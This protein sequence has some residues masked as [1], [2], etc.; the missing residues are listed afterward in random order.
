MNLTARLPLAVAVAC[1]GALAPCRAQLNPDRLY[2]GVDRAIPMTLRAPADAKGE[3]EIALFEPLVD[4]PVATAAAA[5]GRVDL[6]GLFPS[7]WTTREPKVRYA[8]AIVGGVRI[9]APVVLQPMLEPAYAMLDRANRPAFKRLTENKLVYS[10]LRA[11]GD[12]LVVLDTSK[13]EIRIA[14]RPDAAPNTA[15][16]FR[17]LVEGGF[18]D[19]V[20]FH[21]VVAFKPNGDRFVIQTGDPTGTGDGGPGYYIDLENSPLPHDFG[22]V[23][24]ARDSEPN[25]NGSQFFIC[26]GRAGVKHLDGAYTSFAQCVSG[27]EVVLAIAAAPVGP[28]DKPLEPPIIRSAT[29]VESPPYG[30]GAKPVTSPEVAPPGR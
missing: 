10:G 30:Q 19:G 15:W 16:N 12:R 4:E 24:M 9:G 3:V 23:S 8:Q 22:V 20:Q 17:H 27:A 21:R 1:L 18:Y 13:G 11:Y 28:N 14:L 2:Y 26:L 25:T 29:L 6:A 7:L 5:V